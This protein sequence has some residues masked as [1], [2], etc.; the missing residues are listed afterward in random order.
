MEK[1]LK[2]LKSFTRAGEKS[3]LDECFTGER[4]IREEKN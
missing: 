1:P 2:K 4:E 3:I